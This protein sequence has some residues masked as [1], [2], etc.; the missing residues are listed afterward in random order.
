MKQYVKLTAG[1]GR[2]FLL[3]ILRT[4]ENIKEK[5]GI[6]VTCQEFTFH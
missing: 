5:W 4:E 2:L 3:R 6:T 1:N